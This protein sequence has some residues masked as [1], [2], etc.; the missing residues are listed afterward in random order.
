MHSLHR[1]TSIRPYL[2]FPIRLTPFNLSGHFPPT[3]RKD[4]T[5]DNIHRRKTLKSI[6]VYIRI[7]NEQVLL[8]HAEAIDIVCDTA[9]TREA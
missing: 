5:T 6:Y 7:H 1:V 2:S 3:R 8:Q 9:V 4:K